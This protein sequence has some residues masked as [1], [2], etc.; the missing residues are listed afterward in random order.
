MFD[1]YHEWLDIP[2]QK[3]PPSHYQILGIAVGENS[4]EAIKEAALRQTTR[5]RVYQTGPQAA[6]CTR[7][8]NEIAQARTTLQNPKTRQEY[9]AR[10]AASSAALV[11][12]PD[13]IPKLPT[14]ARSPW[15]RPDRLLAAVAYGFLLVCGFA[16]SFCLTF[17]SL[18]TAAHAPAP[19]DPSAPAPVG[20]AEP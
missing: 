2:P 13:P 12:A 18:R 4:P 9:D 20:D 16:I 11:H 3:Q 7:I 17:Q 14:V 5:V 19:V 1:P 6:L 8:L 10:L 15:P